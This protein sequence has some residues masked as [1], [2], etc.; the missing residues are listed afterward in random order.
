MPYPVDAILNQTKGRVVTQFII[1][2]DS[3]IKNIVVLKDIGNGCGQAAYKVIE[4]MNFMKEKWR[5]GYQNGKPVRV[6]Y[7]IPIKFN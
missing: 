3:S 4:S 1:D 6:K 5:P 2:R 7:T